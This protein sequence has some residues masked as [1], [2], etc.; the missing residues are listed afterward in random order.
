MSA[1]AG[2]T[3]SSFIAWSFSPV[4]SPRDGD[5]IPDLHM[6]DNALVFFEIYDKS[7]YSVIFNQRLNLFV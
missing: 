2:P 3:L 7:V 1:W 6:R 5:F 4:L